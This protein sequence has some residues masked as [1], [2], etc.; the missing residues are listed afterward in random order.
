MDFMLSA[1]TNFSDL[2]TTL[3]LTGRA[4]EGERVRELAGG[5]SALVGVVE[6]GREPWVV[7]APLGQLTVNDEWL[8]DRSRGANEAAILAQLDGQL[9]PVR[10]PRLLF[11]DD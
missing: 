10:T 11:F 1:V 8:A 9:G 5:V 6:G 7:K 2:V 4:G 3:Q